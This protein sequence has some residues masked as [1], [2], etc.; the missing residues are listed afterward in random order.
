[1]AEE[2]HFDVKA[3]IG[4]ITLDRP[5]ALNALTLDQIRQMYPRLREWRSDPDV[6]VVVLRSTGGKAFCAGGDIRAL[7]DARKAEDFE[8]LYSFY[9]EEYRLNRLIWTFPK[10]YISFVDG[11][12]MGGGVGISVHGSHRVVTERTMFAM[13]ETGIG[14]FPDVGGTHFLPRCPG[15]IGTYLALTGAR[16]READ[17]LHAGYATHFVPAERLGELDEALACANGQEELGPAVTAMIDSY[18]EDPAPAPLAERQEVIDRCFS[19][20]TVEE[21][22]E[23]LSAEGDEWSLAVRDDLLRKSPLSLK[24]TLRQMQIGRLIDFDRAMQVE[25]RLARRFMHGQDFFEGVRAVIV[26]KDNAPRWQ[27][28]SLADVGRDEVDAYFRPLSQGEE[29]TFED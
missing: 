16:L 8:S 28:A 7:Y 29:L 11:I 3:G 12:V 2:I 1:M 4:H 6:H 24:I 9:R 20:S 26:E 15:A 14:L 21:I 13:P 27:H 22:I 19:K 5:K 18:H 23:A 10:P 17:A 25:Y